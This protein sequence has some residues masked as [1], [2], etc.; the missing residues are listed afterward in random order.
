MD[1]L[2]FK[3]LLEKFFWDNGKNP[4]KEKQTVAYYRT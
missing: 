2:T 4:D 3:A 1:D